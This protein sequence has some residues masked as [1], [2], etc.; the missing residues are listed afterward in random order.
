MGLYIIPG[1]TVFFRKNGAIWILFS[2][3]R[4]IERFLSSYFKVLLFFMSTNGLLRS[5]MKNNFA[6]KIVNQ[7]IKLARSLFRRTALNA[8]HLPV[9]SREVTLLTLPLYRLS[10][11]VS[12]V[13]PTG[14]L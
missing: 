1:L 7:D 6:R 10:S 2:S 13:S 14:Q 4:T 12:N 8:S 9:L 11:W 3:L 5:K